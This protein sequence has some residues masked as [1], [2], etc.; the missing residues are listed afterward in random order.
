[1]C[2]WAIDNVLA[3]SCRP[4]YYGERGLP[5]P[6]GDV[7]AWIGEVTALGI[8][9]IICLLAEDQLPLYAQLPTDLISYYRKAGFT[10]KHVPA[11][12]HQKPPLSDDHLEQIWEAYQ[13]LPKP[14]LVHCSAGIDRTGQ[15]VTYIQQRFEAAS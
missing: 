11:P 13:A 3:R 4:G 6:K 12:D 10:V 5:V 7:D 8:R 14:V 9:S 15:A 2:T 1:M